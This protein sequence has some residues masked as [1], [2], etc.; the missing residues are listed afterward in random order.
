MRSLHQTDAHRQGVC[1]RRMLISVGA[2][3]LGF[4][5]SVLPLYSNSDLQPTPPGET[6]KT[7]LYGPPE[8]IGMITDPAVSEVS[9]LAVSTSN[10]DILWAIN[11]SGHPPTLYALASSGR[12]M[13]QFNV[14]GADNIDWEAIALFNVND[15]SYLMIADVGDNNGRYGYRTLYIVKE[16]IIKT[17]TD[18][19][20][21]LQGKI[22]F[23]YED[24]PRDC[25]AVAVDVN[26]RRILLLSKRDKPPCLYALPLNF[27][28]VLPRQ[29]LP[30]K[31]QTAH[32]IALLTTLPPLTKKD[33]RYKYGQYAA[34]PTDMTLSPDGAL[35]TILTYT[36]IYQYQRRAKQCWAE[37]LQAQ[38]IRIDLPH[39]STGL[40]KQRESLARHPITGDIF[41]TSEGRYARIF[42]IQCFYKP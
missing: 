40:L 41:I 12:M 35:L 29:A 7:D 24:G 18:S 13:G 21:K 10:H 30:E 42:R 36:N 17:A 25:E 38:P 4:F 26:S 23:Q 9:G 27:P 1:S 34:C 20:L 5:L 37:A 31:V 15:T 8:K 32:R 14:T 22:T 39:P 33:L 19:S 28:P 11:D 16:P 6:G 3:F 2:V